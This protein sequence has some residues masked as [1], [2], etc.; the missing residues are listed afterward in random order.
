[1]RIAFGISWN[2]TKKGQL[3]SALLCSF[4]VLTLASPTQMQASATAASELVSI[5]VREAPGSGSA[6]EQAVAELNGSVGL[7]LDVIDG[8][9]AELPRAALPLLEQNDD[10][11]SVS[12]N[13]PVKMLSTS[14]TFDARTDRGSWSNV[15]AAVKAKDYWQ[16]GFRGQ[17]VDI[18][19]IDTGVVPVDGLQGPKVYLGPDLT[20]E[21]LN[22]HLHGLDTYG[23]G[24][25]MAGIIAGK[26][27]G[28]PTV[29]RE[30]PDY[31]HGIAPD[32]RLVSVKVAGASGATDV[33]QIIAAIDW[34]IK[35]RNKNGLNIKV[36]NLSFGTDSTQDY[37]VDPM[38]YAA[39]AA[40]HAGITVVAAAG[41]HGFGDTRLNNPAYNPYLIAVGASDTNGTYDTDD[42]IV[43]EW[44]ARGDGTRNP[45][46][47]APGKSSVSLRAPGSTIDNE[48]PGGRAS[49]KYFRGSGTSQAAAVVAGAAALVVNERPGIT[50]D[51]V[52]ALL[53]GTARHLPIADPVRQGAGSLDLKTARRTTTPAAVQ[54]WD[55]STGLGS[56]D[57]AR[58]SLRIERDGVVLTGE[59]DIFGQAWD[60][61]AWA[62]GTGWS[63]TGWSGTGWSGT[64]WSGTGWSGTGWSDMFWNG[65]GWSGTGWSGTG[66]SGT[67]WSG[68]GWSGTGW[69]GTGWSGTGWSG[70]GWSGTGWSG[71]GWSGTGWSGTGWSGTG[72][73]GTGWS[74]TGWSGTGWSGTGWSGTGWS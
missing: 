18:A 35:N 19:L 31:F 15:A 42:D 39:E 27:N 64:G 69:S 53:K 38:S 34:V 72:W 3:V 43:P 47:V 45:D 25:H 17:G 73:S 7:Q 9:V 66:W 2:D 16:D 1:V 63:G 65:T 51:Q 6:A 14:T 10:V 30:N 59:Q 4:L 52:K 46:F 50:P 40:W 49:D 58:G 13:R 41:N 5:I 56:L 55:R 68:T 8:F 33:S 54:T 12:I 29:T 44:S 67:G 60:G 57:A 61:A 20:M 70:T 74:G 26:A 28:T 62:N 32:A 37:R 48:F 36:L 23:H 24:T 71:T 22:P 21:G 11:L